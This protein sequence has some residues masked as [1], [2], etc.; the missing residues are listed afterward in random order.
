MKSSESGLIRIT[1]GST[2]HALK[3]LKYPRWEDFNYEHN[4]GESS[5]N[6]LYWLGNGMTNNEKTLTG[7]ST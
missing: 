4:D 3:A 5:H 2:L 6:S 1:I 7:D